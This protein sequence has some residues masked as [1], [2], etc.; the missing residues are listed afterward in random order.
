M[1]YR[2]DVARDPHIVRDVVFYEREAGHTEQVLDVGVV[3]GR[4]V[5]D[6]DNLVAAS[7]ELVGEVRAKEAGSAGDDDA[8]HQ[9]RPTPW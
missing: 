1:E 2:I 3:A 9:K 7:E 5:V 6:G 8:S 4:E